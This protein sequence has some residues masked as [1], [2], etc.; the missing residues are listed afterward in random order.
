MGGF[1]AARIS[2]QTAHGGVVVV[3][4]PTVIIGK[5]PAARIGDMHTCPMAT[6]PVPHV[7]GPFIL[8]SPT[9][10]VGAMPQSRVTDTL[11]CVGP[12][13]VLVKGEPTVLI[14]M[15]G[16]M[17][18][19]GL[20]RGMVMAGV[21]MLGRV[22]DSAA[23][24]PRIQANADGTYTTEFSPNLTIGPASLEYNTAVLS[25]LAN[26]QRPLADGR[27]STGSKLIKKLNA[28]K[29][30]VTIGPLS[31]DQADAY[32]ERTGDALWDT[33]K[34]KRGSGSD[35][36]VRY[37]P[38]LSMQYTAEDGTQ[39]VMPPEHVMAH[40]LIHA[41][42]NQRGEN[43][44][45]ETLPSPYDNNEEARTIGVHGHEGEEISERKLSEEAGR[46]ARPDHDSSDSMTYKASDGNWYDRTYD[47][48]GNPVDTPT[49]APAGQA[50]RPNQ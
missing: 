4:Y 23:S 1:P 41:T 49:A 37:N 6:G 18:F 47:A 8:G 44:R 20:L 29:H 40:E 5:M 39:E 24:F 10:L 42:H 35:S 11:V 27:E 7:G 46:S 17:G 26:L 30:H 31:G 22:F 15:V 33:A 14:G 34:N 38:S 13:D 3:G 25:D 9:V 50:G 2:D 45:N 43:R 12:P 21:A 32:C 16:A 48:S 19:M 28:G 36:T